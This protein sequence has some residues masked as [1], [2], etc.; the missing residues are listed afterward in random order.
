MLKALTKLTILTFSLT[1]NADYG[2]VYVD[3]IVSVYDGDTFRA[4]IRQWPDILGDNIGIRINGIDTPEIRGK[5]ELEKALAKEARQITYDSLTQAESVELRNIDRGKYFRVVA[6]V[7]IDGELL[8]DRLS[9]K[10]LAY[11]YDGGTKQSW[12]E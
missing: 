5:C 12:C 6:D 8:I 9:E 10:K 7:Y 1:V 11:A 4:N 2:R 3:E